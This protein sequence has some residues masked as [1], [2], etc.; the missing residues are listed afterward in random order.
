MLV[1]C[2][3]TLTGFC[4]TPP[5]DPPNQKQEYTFTVDNTSYEKVVA[6][7]IAS[8]DVNYSC[9]VSNEQIFENKVVNK[10]TGITVAEAAV[11]VGWNVNTYYNLYKQY[12]K[13]NETGETYCNIPVD[14]GLKYQEQATINMRSSFEGTDC[15]SAEALSLSLHNYYKNSEFNAKNKKI[16]AEVC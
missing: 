15:T 16:P 5:T 7:Y 3:A 12:L 8:L 4:F 11:D 2:L 14:V 1:V 10:V 13:V 9:N 6:N